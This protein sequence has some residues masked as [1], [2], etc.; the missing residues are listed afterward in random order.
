MDLVLLTLV[1]VDV[2]V[3]VVVRVVVLV[4]TE[5]SRVDVDVVDDSVV[6]GGV[7]ENTWG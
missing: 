3:D 4:V 5:R 1:V 7:V 2:V 6:F